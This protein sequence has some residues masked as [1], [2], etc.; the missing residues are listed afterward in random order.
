MKKFRPVACAFLLCAIIVAPPARAN[1]TASEEQFREYY[2][3]PESPGPLAREILSADEFKPGLIEQLLNEVRTWIAETL[4]EIFFKLF[5]QFHF[6]HNFNLDKDLSWSVFVGALLV[7]LAIAVALGLWYA[8][9]RWGWPIRRVSRA[10]RNTHDELFSAAHSGALWDQAVIMAERGDYGA[11]MILLFRFV[12]MSLQEKGLLSFHRG[13]T[14]REIL[15]TLGSVPF[16][17]VLAEMVL[18]FNRVRYGRAT[19]GQADYEE[20]LGLCRQVAQQL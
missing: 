5:R 13:K 1:E 10:E 15:D 4:E 11:A 7:L 9:R 19:C 6:S 3:L 2:R 20:F 8:F 12:L 16:R 17:D 18:R 14:N